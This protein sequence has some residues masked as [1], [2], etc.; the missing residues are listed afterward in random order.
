[1]LRVG[2]SLGV[3]GV[4]ED[5][6]TAGFAAKGLRHRE[7]AVVGHVVVDDKNVG[8]QLARQTQRAH[9]VA[10]H[11]HDLKVRLNSDEISQVLSD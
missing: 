2:A 6:W 10:H 7:A 8:P 4:E 1:M 11:A 5:T 9:P 3:H